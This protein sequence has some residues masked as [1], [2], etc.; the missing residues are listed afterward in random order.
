MDKT[1]SVDLEKLFQKLC[2]TKNKMDDYYNTSEEPSV[3]GILKYG[4]CLRGI[5]IISN[6]L[7]DN[8]NSFGIDIDAR[9]I[10]EDLAIIN[11]LNNGLLSWEQFYVA[12]FSKI[13]VSTDRYLDLYKSIMQSEKIKILEDSK[14]NCIKAVLKII[15]ITKVE[16]FNDISIPFC[17]LKYGD[18]TK[19]MKV[20]EFITESLTNDFE[21]MRE[22]FSLNIH[23]AYYSEK[24]H[25]L[26]KKYRKEYIFAILDVLNSG[27]TDT[28]IDFSKCQSYGDY[29]KVRMSEDGTNDIRIV[30]KV[31]NETFKESN[32]MLCSSFDK[33]KNLMIDVLLSGDLLSWSF[34]SGRIKILYE[35]CSMIY[36]VNKTNT[37]EMWKKVSDYNVYSNVDNNASL[38]VKKRQIM[39]ELIGEIRTKHHLENVSDKSLANTI[40]E[41]ALFFAYGKRTSFTKM[42]KDFINSTTTSENPSF[43]YKLYKKSLSENH[44]SFYYLTGEFSYNYPNQGKLIKTYSFGFIWDLYFYLIGYPKT[45]NERDFV[46][47]N[48]I[49]YIM[50]K[51]K[52]LKDMFAYAIEKSA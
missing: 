7:E 14:E 31:F 20:S 42:V 28:D 40:K 36:L 37:A 45:V 26:V 50:D 52:T 21:V 49:R 10:I 9:S 22:F 41:C 33:I 15:S 8:F 25:E 27:I 43:Y 11:G 30:R 13:Y 23:P 46:F 24:A 4:I 35:Y 5:S 16:L 29:K 1:K 19:N 44:G 48:S 17:F 18:H 39:D 3:D 38:D 32:A 12:L 51:E 6:I 2:Y 47:L 34:A